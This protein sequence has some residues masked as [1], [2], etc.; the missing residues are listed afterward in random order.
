MA[1]FMFLFGILYMTWNVEQIAHHRML[2]ALVEKLKD[3]V[4]Y[5]LR[6]IA[7]VNYKEIDSSS[8][9]EDN[10]DATSEVSQEESEVESEE[11]ESEEVESEEVESEE[12][13]PTQ[14]ACKR[15]RDHNAIGRMI[16]S[17]Y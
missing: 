1:Y 11:V 12:V 2:E 4:H 14:T 13:E 6:D 8:E 9:E 7:R 15:R 5:N 10:Q 3:N 16:D 17:I